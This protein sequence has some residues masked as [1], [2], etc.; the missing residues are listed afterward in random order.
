MGLTFVKKYNNFVLKIPNEFRSKAD[1][2]KTNGFDKIK[3]NNC[4]TI[5][6]AGL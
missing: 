1:R 3:A 4:K 2:F 6:T 5:P